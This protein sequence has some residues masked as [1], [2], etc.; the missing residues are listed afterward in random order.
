MTTQRRYDIDW[1][2]VIA[3]ALL[4]IY[5]IAIVFQPWAMFLGFIKSNELMEG[6]WKPMSLL[7]VWRIPF[8]FYV[9]GMGVYF[10]IRKR[11][12]KQLLMERS[13]RILLP[14]LFGMVAIVP[15]HFLIFQ[16]YYHLPLG[17]VPHPAHL[18][19]LGNIFAYVLLLTPL[20]F[21]L[22]KNESGRFKRKLEA[23]MGNPFGPL[24][25]SLLFVLEVLLVKPQVFEMYALTWHGFFLGLLA[26]FCGFLLV[27]SGKAFW[28]TILKWRWAYLA[29]AL[30]FY[31]TRLLVFDLAAPG[32]LLAIESNTWIFAIFGFGYKYLNKPSAL[33]SYLSQAAYPVYIIHMVALHAAA[34]VILPFNLPVLL[35]F[36]GIV[37]FTAGFCFVVFEF[38]IRRIPFLRPLFGLSWDFKKAATK[39]I[40]VSA[41]TQKI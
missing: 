9:S 14:F 11:N 27:Y 36:I 39:S 28:E 1:L 15:L 10:A 35:K 29:L 21:F 7:N 2:R 12:W 22:K 41:S 8:L 32:Y 30:G 31:L 17:Y 20:F 23:F 16:A 13:K 3:I 24:S 34:W 6:L 26:F 25:L 40:S 33:L 38:L 18:W 37:G 5:H 19:F 4:L